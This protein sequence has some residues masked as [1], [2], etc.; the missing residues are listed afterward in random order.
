MG[1]Y[2]Q[3]IIYGLAII[4]TD[5]AQD[6]AAGSTDEST[7]FASFVALSVGATG[8]A[9]GLGNHWE[10]AT[11]SRD[12]QSMNMF[13]L[14]DRKDL[15]A[16]INEVATFDESEGS[17]LSSLQDVRRQHVGARWAILYLEFDD[18]DPAALLATALVELR[19]SG[20]RRMNMAKATGVGETEAALGAVLKALN[21]LLQVELG[22]KMIVD[23]PPEEEITGPYDI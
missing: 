2:G 5:G 17:F 11:V 21:P 1:R 13:N 9:F 7:N 6:K 18:S 15:V 4:F 23:D 14:T 12:F 22:T 3:T 10:P 8:Q 16:T 19:A 20:I